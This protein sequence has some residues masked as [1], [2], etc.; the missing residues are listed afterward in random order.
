[1]WQYIANA[2]PSMIALAAGAGAMVL[3]LVIVFVGYGCLG[4]DSSCDK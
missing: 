3:F 1:M 2:D 4:W